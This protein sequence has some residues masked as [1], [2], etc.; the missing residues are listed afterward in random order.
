M[1]IWAYRMTENVFPKHSSVLRRYCVGI[2]SVL[3]SALLATTL[4]AH[5]GGWEEFL[6]RCVTPM[7]AGGQPAVIGLDLIDE[8]PVG[9]A[10]DLPGETHIAIRPPFQ[11]FGLQ[12]LVV[13]API[14]PAKL[15]FDDWITE[16]VEGGRYAADA[17]IESRWRS[18]GE[19]EAPMALDAWQQGDR[20]V[21]Q[22]SLLEAQS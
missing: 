21:F 14:D 10:F 11:A 22:L 18:L 2:T 17:D 3:F 13:T 20:M 15:A 7:E 12:C 6:K 9:Q 4:P 5:A 16:V 19:I 8:D 1:L